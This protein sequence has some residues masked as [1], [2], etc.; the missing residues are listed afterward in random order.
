[1]ILEVAYNITGFAY[2]TNSMGSLTSWLPIIAIV[3]AASIVLGIVLTAISFWWFRKVMDFINGFTGTL[4][5]ALYGGATVGCFGVVSFGIWEFLA[6]NAE[7][8]IPL[9]YYP[10]GVVGYAFLYAIGKVSENVYQR[11]EKNYNKA[12]KVKKS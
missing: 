1:M 6:V 10:L 4:K 11:L 7:S 5:Y 8:N 3:I 2:A 12:M 9:W